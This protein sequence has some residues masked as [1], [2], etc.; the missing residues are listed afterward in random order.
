[1]QATLGKEIHSAR[2]R[3]FSFLPIY[4]FVSLTYARKIV[5]LRAHSAQ[6]EPKAKYEPQAAV[7]DYFCSSRASSPYLFCSWPDWTKKRG[8]TAVRASNQHASRASLFIPRLH[9]LK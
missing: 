6:L 8:G 4:Y 3:C 1:M 2:A 7:P 9:L 5:V